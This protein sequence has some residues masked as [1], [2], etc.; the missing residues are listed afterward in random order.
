MEH[1]NRLRELSDSIKCDNNCIIGVSEE[2]T[3]GGEILFHEIIAENF[4]NFG[5]ETHIR[6]TPI[7]INKSR[8]MTRHIVIKFAKYNDKE[9]N[10]K[11]SNTKEDSNIQE[12]KTIRLAGDFSTETKQARREWHDIFKVLKGKNLQPRTLSFRIEGE[13]KSFPEKQKLKECVTKLALQE[14]LKGTH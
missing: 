3:K 5:K 10:L 8:P 2:V 7:K 11:N 13:V 1:E 4:P 9:K 14:I 6:R 12:K